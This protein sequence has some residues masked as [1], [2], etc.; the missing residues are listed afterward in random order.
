MQEKFDALQGELRKLGL[1]KKEATIYLLL[2]EEGSS[3][4]LQIAKKLGFSR[5]T[6]Y[7]TLQDLQNKELVFFDKEKK[8]S[9]FTASSPDSLMR[10]LKIQKRKVEEQEREFMRI[11]SVLQSKFHLFANKNEIRI[12]QK[13]V[14]LDDLPTALGDDILVLYPN[15]DK[16]SASDCKIME[17]IYPAVRKRLGKI[18]VREI[19]AEKLPPSSL[20]FVQRKIIDF[21]LPFSKT[22]IV[23]KN[24]FILDK[25]KGIHIEEKNTIETLK[26]LFELLWK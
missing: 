13:R 22:L 24:A 14:L 16:S 19:S 3:T 25:D 23:S 1:N 9:S 2:L 15:Q 17:K 18:T 21:P 4:V 20:S 26:F 8:K 10:I 7:R 12:Y 11:I 6:V 5:P